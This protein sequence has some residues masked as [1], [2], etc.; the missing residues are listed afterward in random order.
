MNGPNPDEK[1]T[2]EIATGDQMSEA[3]NRFGPKALQ[4]LVLLFLV[5]PSSRHALCGD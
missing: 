5:F 1:L 2:E 4:C 3:R